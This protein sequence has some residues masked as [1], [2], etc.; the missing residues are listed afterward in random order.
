MPAYNFSG[1]FM[2]GMEGET[3]E[4]IMKV[5]GKGKIA[6]KPDRIRLVLDL[7]GVKEHYGEALSESGKHSM[8][9]KEAVEKAGFCKEDLKTTSFHINTKY[10][11]YQTEDRGWKKRFAGY[12]WRHGMHLEFDAK[13]EL[14][15]S[16]LQEFAKVSVTPEFSIVYFVKDSEGAKKELLKKAVEDS[17]S[18]AEILAASAGV[19][20][21]EVKSIDYSFEENEICST[22]MARMALPVGEHERGIAACSL[23]MVPEDISVTDTVTVIWEIN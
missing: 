11:N 21:G 23:D 8:S 5:T 22:T 17:K 16:V 2:A 18:K 20:L 19:K 15:G 13:N 1:K 7:S 12:E 10:E 3:M 14:L 4:R 9:L 6:V